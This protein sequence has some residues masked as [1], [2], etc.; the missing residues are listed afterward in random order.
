MLAITIEAVPA[1]VWV[2]TGLLAFAGLCTLLA[3]IRGL[4]HC[5][6]EDDKLVQKNREQ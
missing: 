4:F 3:C 2:M 6:A 5:G 1:T